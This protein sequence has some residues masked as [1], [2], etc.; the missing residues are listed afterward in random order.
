MEDLANKIIKRF[1]EKYDFDFTEYELDRIGSGGEAVVYDSPEFKSSVIRIGNSSEFYKTLYE[2]NIELEYSVKVKYYKEFKVPQERFNLSIAIL[3]K[4][5][6]LPDDEYSVLET[7]SS[8]NI[9]FYT[10]LDVI[11]NGKMMDFEDIKRFSH[12]GNILDFDAI[13]LDEY[14][15]EI[16]GDLLIDVKRAIEEI[17]TKLKSY[18]RDVWYGNILFN[19]KLKRYQ[20]ID[21]Q[22]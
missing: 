6:A 11:D 13:L 16:I 17:Q 10:L 14:D 3:D 21:I 2:G 12:L 9:E 19:D 1:N 15:F 22:I 18:A 7:L 20:L 4:L 5:S 8:N